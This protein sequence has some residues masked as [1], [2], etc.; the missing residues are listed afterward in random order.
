MLWFLASVILRSGL[1]ILLA[2]LD[3][4]HRATMSTCMAKPITT[5]K[6]PCRR[7]SEFPG[8]A[9]YIAIRCATRHQDFHDQEQSSERAPVTLR[10]YSKSEYKFS[11][12]RAGPSLISA[13]SS[14]NNGNPE[15]VDWLNSFD[16][17]LLKSQVSQN[18]PCAISL[19]DISDI[20]VFSWRLL[21]RCAPLRDV[22]TLDRPCA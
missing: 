16:L 18:R 20:L 4:P 2:G 5:P 10:S 3:R 7:T 12:T 11:T 6:Q 15:R 21:N 9:V 13:K 14:A 8:Q 19:S 17:P 1:P 22:Y